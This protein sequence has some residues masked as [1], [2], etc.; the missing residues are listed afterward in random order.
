MLAFRTAGLTCG[1]PDSP[2]LDMSHSAANEEC[3]IERPPVDGMIRRLKNQIYSRRI[4]E[5]DEPIAS[6]STS[7]LI[8]KELKEYNV[9]HV[10]K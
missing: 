5:R 8:R 2:I 6:R 10:H 7:D 3:Y 4:F 1:A 9:N